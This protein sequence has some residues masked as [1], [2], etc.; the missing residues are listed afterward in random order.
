MLVHAP[1]TRHSDTLRFHV[2]RHHRA[3]DH[4]EGASALLCVTPLDGYVSPNWYVVPGDQVPTWNYVAIEV[5]GVLR[6][7]DEAELVDQL[8]ELARVHE[9]RVNPGA[10]WTRAK[11]NP[12]RFQAMLAGIRGF[13]LCP[14]AI[15]G[16]SKLSQNKPVADR[17]GVVAG[18]YAAGNGMMAAAMEDIAAAIQGSSPI[19]RG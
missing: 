13:E 18:M 11:M 15:R 14:N 2:S 19:P 6:R 12:A 5:E 1:V 9:P 8:D 3:A 10:P 7:L 17:A 4:L 16:T